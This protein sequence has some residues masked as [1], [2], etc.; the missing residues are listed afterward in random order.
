[1]FCV[2]IIGPPSPMSPFTIIEPQNP[3]I[4]EFR[5]VWE[6]I[7]TDFKATK[8][9][10]GSSG[11][12][13]SNCEISQRQIPRMPFIYDRGS[14]RLDFYIHTSKFLTDCPYCYPLST[15]FRYI[16]KSCFVWKSSRVIGIIQ[17][18]VFHSYKISENI[19]RGSLFP[20][21]NK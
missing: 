6:R 8:L 13:N 7:A 1:M 3:W 20:D 18:L 16:C 15:L 9:G 4:D 21:S 12:I 2:L 5:I 14:T 17:S 11:C 10:K 19:C